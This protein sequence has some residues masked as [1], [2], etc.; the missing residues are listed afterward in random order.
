MLRADDTSLPLPIKYV[1]FFSVCGR[2]V[3]ADDNGRGKRGKEV[4]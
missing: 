1:R 3:L 2:R 4:R